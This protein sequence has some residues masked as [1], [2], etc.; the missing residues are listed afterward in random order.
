MTNER[1]Y[2]AIEVAEIVDLNAEIQRRA[3]VHIRNF[4]G[5]NPDKSKLQEMLNLIRAYRNL[6]PQDVH[7]AIYGQ[8]ERVEE[9]F[10]P[11]IDR[12]VELAQ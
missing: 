2:T 11:L 10:Q 7:S 9:A 1:K 8:Y 12:A 4:E 3:E 5:R 6:V